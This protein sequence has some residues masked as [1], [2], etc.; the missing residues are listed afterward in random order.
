MFLKILARQGLAFCG[1]EDKDNFD[2]L[3]KLS[4]RFILESNFPYNVLISKFLAP[5]DGLHLQIIENVF[6]TAI[7]P[8]A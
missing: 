3:M 5:Q 8:T 1:N 6:W 4:S 2:Q 7:N